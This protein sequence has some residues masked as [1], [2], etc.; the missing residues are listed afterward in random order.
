MKTLQSLNQK[1]KNLLAKSLR[2]SLIIAIFTLP[3]CKSVQTSFVDFE[4]CSLADSAKPIQESEF[5]VA[6]AA[7]VQ[8][9]YNGDAISQKNLAY[10]YYYGNSH[11]PQNVSEGIKWFNEAAKQGNQTAMARVQDMNHGTLLS[12]NFKPY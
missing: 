9:A 2:L 11:V 8:K 1:P 6:F 5:K 4:P 3:A 12:Y 7:C 10:I